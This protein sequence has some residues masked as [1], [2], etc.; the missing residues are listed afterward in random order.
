MSAIPRWQDEW[1]SVN[2]ARLSVDA[3]RERLDIVRE[4][5]HEGVSYEGQ[6][7]DVEHARD[8]EAKVLAEADAGSIRDELHAARDRVASTDDGSVKTVEGSNVD[9]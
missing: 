8:L 4:R 2:V 9:V 5:L 7:A 3:A 1:Q 6:E